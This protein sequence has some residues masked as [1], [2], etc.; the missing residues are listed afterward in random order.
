LEMLCL[1]WLYWSYNCICIH[2]HSCLG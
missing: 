2:F 1:W